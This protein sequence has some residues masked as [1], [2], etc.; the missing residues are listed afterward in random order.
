M[1]SGER[2]TK[3][4]VNNRQESAG[5][6]KNYVGG[7]NFTQRRS[8]GPMT[9]KVTRQRVLSK[10]LWAGKQKDSNNTN[11]Q[12]CLRLCWRPWGFK[13]DFRWNSVHFRKSNHSFPLVG[14]ARNKRQFPRVLQYPKSFRWMLDCEWMDYLLS[15]YG[16]WRLKGCVRQTAPKHKFIR[17]LE[18]DARQATVREGQPNPNK[19]ETEML[20]NCR[21]WT[22]SP[23]MHIFL[24]ASL[25]FK[26][27][28]TMNQQSKWL[29][30]AEVQQW[31]TCQ[32]PTEVR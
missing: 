16:L 8:R 15:I 24:K 20:S 12:L 26:F 27:L 7:K 29:L 4:Q 28:R 13:I 17:H 9:W 5:A 19:R 14:C 21:M 18:T 6:T 3:I 22:M 25:S 10:M 2:L 11:S 31:D 30:K 23:Q 32:E 1:W